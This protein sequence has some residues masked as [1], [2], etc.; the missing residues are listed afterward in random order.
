[1]NNVCD[2]SG[3][4]GVEID[5]E[6]EIFDTDGTSSLVFNDDINFTTNYCSQA[7]YT[8]AA[9]R[10]Y[11]LRVSNSSDFCPLCLFDY[12]VTIGIE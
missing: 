7:S 10:T 11:F 8:S 1:V 2:G 5:T 6:I 3:V 12:G 9:G 4:P